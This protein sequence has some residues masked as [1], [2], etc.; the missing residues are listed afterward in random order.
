MAEAVAAGVP[1]ALADGVPVALP[2][3]V[4][5]AVAAGVPEAV[6]GAE[7]DGVAV[8]VDVP[9]TVSVDSGVAVG[10]V[11]QD[12]VAGGEALGV[13]D[14]AAASPST[15]GSTSTAGVSQHAR[16]AGKAHA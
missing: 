14:P 5:L 6:A 12:G 8:G 15:T 13:R 11:K 3:G 4:P 10:H 2:L 9:D 1:V 7:L 16:A